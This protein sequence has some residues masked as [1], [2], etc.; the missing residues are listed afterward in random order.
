MKSKLKFLNVS[1]LVPFFGLMGMVASNAAIISINFHVGDD[2][3]AQADHELTGT[4]AA[5]LDGNTSWNNVNVGVGATNPAAAE[6]FAPVTLSDDSGNASAGTLTSTLTAGTTA[7]WFAGYAATQASANGEIGLAGTNDDDLF[8]SYLALNGPNGD[9][10]P[11]DNF[12]LTVSGLG[13]DYTTFGY[14]IVIY[15]DSDR[16]NSTAANV[17][18]SVFTISPTGGTTSTILVEDDDAT[19]AVN[20]FA[21]T[22]IESDNDTTGADYSNYTVLEGLTA[23][24]FEIEV[25]SPDGGRGAISGF[26]IIANVPEPSTFGLLGLT[27]LGLGLRRR[28]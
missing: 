27:L 8:N 14:S 4:E 2:N 7:T 19:E 3:D 16:R 17:R 22:Y 13:A 9:G 25:T 5:G 21:G 23:D 15:S 26:Q 24:T 6:I 28:R 12:V 1:A 18:T 10:T 11:L 20:T